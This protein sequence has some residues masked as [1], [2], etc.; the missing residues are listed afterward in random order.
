MRLLVRRKPGDFC[1]L[2]SLLMARQLTLAE[3][4]ARCWPVRVAGV[5]LSII[6]PLTRGIARGVIF[7]C[8]AGGAFLF[9]TVVT[10]ASSGSQAG[11]VGILLPFALSAL[12]GVCM[13]RPIAPHGL[14]GRSLQGVF[15]TIVTLGTLIAGVLWLGQENSL[16]GAPAH[17]IFAVVLA[18]V[19]LLAGLASGIMALVGL[20]PAF[21]PLLNR[22]T[23]IVGMASLLLTFSAVCIVFLGSF[24][25]TFDLVPP[26]SQNQSTDA[27][28]LKI[29]ISQAVVRVVAMWI[30]LLAV[31]G[32]G[33]SEL[34]VSAG[35]R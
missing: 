12:I 23:W 5:A 35:G 3:C 8:I 10:L 34:L 28:V 17:L 22:A 20:K 32:A 27:R 31:L 2:D 1:L 18:I 21:T 25:R 14:G 19:G 29:V 24:D 6:T 11:F 33:I 26:I 13:A 9:L 7:T 15:G 30:S 4:R 16:A